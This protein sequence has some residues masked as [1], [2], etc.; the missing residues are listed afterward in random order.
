MENK[1]VN[2]KVGSVMVVGGG[3]AGMQS[4]LDLAES[5]Y[6]V[7]LVE[8][9]PSIGGRMA[10]L[11]KTF[12]T[13]DCAMCTL[14]PKLAQANTHP[15]ITL[16]CYSEV[17]SI[18][19][20]P[21][22]FKARI[23]EK[24]TR[25]DWSK[26]T[27]CGVC[28]EWCPVAIPNE[29]NESLDNRRAI[30][31]AFPQA[32]P[33]KYVIDKKE[34][35]LCHAACT[36]ACPLHMN[37]SGYLKA[38]SEGLI[39]DAYK[40]IR[41]TNPLPAI[42]GRVC[43]APCQEACNRGQIDEH[44]AIR[45]VK[46]FIAD[47]ADASK[48]QVSKLAST[49]KKVAIIGSGPA[50]LTAAHDLALKGH[51]VVIFEALPKPG[52]MLQVGIPEYRLPKDV[53]KKEISQIE[54]LGVEIKTGVTIGKDVTLKELKDNYDAIFVAV[55]AHQGTKLR[56]PGEGLEGVVQGVDFLRRANLGETIKVPNEVAVIGG[57]NT[58]IDC[59]RTVKRLGAK[60]VT[61]FYRRTKEEMPAAREEIEA[62]ENE[63]VKTEL[64]VTPIAFHGEKSLSS[65]ELIRM[66]LG[67]PDASGRPR[68]IPVQGSEFRVALTMVIVATGQAPVI[69]FLKE[70]GLNISGHGTI[71]ID[72]VSMA[73]N[74]AGVYAGGDAVTGPAF[75]VDA[76]AAGRAA[77]NSIDAFLKGTTVPA[78]EE[79]K[80]EKLS[81]EEVVVVKRF[82][83]PGKRRQMKETATES[84]GNFSEV[85]LGYTM[86]E[87][88]E[89]AARCLAGLEPGCIACLE[90]VRRCEA[91]AV[92]H[93]MTDSI[94]EIDVGAVILASGYE[95][96]DPGL[97][98]EL[99]Y[100]RYDNVVSSLQYERML[101]AS[102]PHM[103]T[104]LRP[105]DLKPPKRIAYIQCV[106]S[107]EIDRNY[108]SSV[109]CMYATKE[110]IITREHAPETE[111]TI[112][113]IDLRAFGKGYE[114][115]Y[116]RAKELGVRYIRCRPSSV[117]EVPGS[118]NLVLRFEKEDGTLVN[119]EFDLVVLSAG[120]KPGEATKKLTD[121]F[122]IV[123]NEYG[124]AQI[125]ELTPAETSRTGIYAAGVIAGPKDI[126]ESVMEASA[127]A[128]RAMSLL[129]GVRGTLVK[130]KTY[131]PERNVT[132]QEPRIGVF[133]CHCGQNIAGVVDVKDV[134]A[135]AKTLPNVVY[136]EDN[137]YTCSTDSCERIKKM[138]LE[139]DLNRVIVASCTPRT[140]EP[141]F[142]DTV[143]QAGLN[144]YLFEMANI[145]DQCS[146]VH[147]HEPQKATKKAK[148]LVRIAVAKSRLLEPLYP[149]YVDV[150]PQALVLGGGLAGM[151]AALEL[152]KQGFETYLLEKSGELGGNLKRVRFLLDH[153]SPKE[154][155]NYL[156]YEVKNHPK[157]HIFTNA[158]V[159]DFEG[160]A[161]NF[162]TT[163]TA[164]GKTQEIRHGAVI[165]AT[166]AR[167]YRPTEFLYGQHPAVISQLEFEDK[168]AS[169][170][171][172]AKSVVMVQCVGPCSQPDGYCSRICCGQ[173]VK[174]ALRV[175]ETKPDTSVFIVHNDMR[176][177]GFN[178]AYYREAR[179]KGVRFIRLAEETQPEVQPAN[180]KV[181][182]SLID[183]IL[184]SRLNIDTDLLVL[185]T[186]IVPDEGNQTLAQKLK[187]PLTQDG[188]FLEAH[189]KLRPV[190]FASDGIF[191]CGLA[192]SPKTADESIA[193][194]MA[195]A[196]RAAT[197]LSKKRIELQAAISNV[198]DEN[199]DG[200]A[201][202]VDPC[203][204]KAITLIEYMKNGE[205]KKTVDADPAKCQ[206]CGV[207][208][209]TCP[210]QGI[211]VLNFR[212]DQLGAMVEA[213]LAE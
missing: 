116:H 164:N 206:G 57:G 1:G 51:G 111:C 183:N 146:W 24:S 130:E 43:Y 123:T 165:V 56:V 41:A 38:A 18:S 91:K 97:K 202:C 54:S 104:V 7:Y 136:A 182:V 73:T 121:T 210:K 124:F 15:N 90:C 89:E 145:R 80:P 196:A 194:A 126:P 174:T 113:Y 6:K 171:F 60:N 213:A 48:L 67:E 139:Q 62:A 157:V 75:V 166:G 199:C 106:G 189:L 50:G 53:V 44:L 20:E 208:Q 175:K 100:G 127:A 135:Y 200:C 8:S 11:D 184:K 17:E 61:I 34:E 52:G 13:N 23:K 4:A 185:S 33:K 3:I 108:C 160:S 178:E 88:Q 179:E 173:A 204:Y 99:G 79:H 144:P 29:F 101:S 92:N 96:I 21:G 16:L 94:K 148:D 27:G 64:L 47:N 120:M 77:A 197:I 49:G 46:R 118:K 180:G 155:L 10:Q 98:K 103:G 159:V 168:L 85:A 161:G 12:P 78:S 36:D 203:P 32:V 72:P 31:T 66:K 212:L 39:D 26:C 143:R 105:S 69:E 167:E 95:I 131:P 198:I 151:T 169:G 162:K 177:Y 59:A 68:P 150:N 84:R 110:A 132:G 195:A 119:E 186:G 63:G 14:G 112:F 2:D 114:H 191:L 129:A 152:G 190:D 154:K 9:S 65:M 158:E 211:S 205:I 83:A 163:F 128:S 209:A 82:V 55:G 142:R 170:N 134:V 19:G 115:Y 42:C 22:H 122:G 137:V 93:N 138:I 71:E 40:L 207:C 35:R 188:F 193:Q 58:A 37:V 28:A 87:A 81:E 176:T 74:I 141:L 187:L 102:G 153:V 45:D 156:I 109:C 30:Y 5:G 133:V 86:A 201:Y 149:A 192:H 181:R 125:G 107:R 172:N 70:I 147:M 140:H 76:M 25:V 117:R